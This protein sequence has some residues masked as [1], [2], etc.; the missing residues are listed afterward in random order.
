MKIILI[1]AGRIGS[2]LAFHLARAGHDVTV[3]ARGKRLDAL[4]REGA[5]VTVEG[6]RA[7]VSMLAELDPATPYDLAI[8][9][10]P[11]HQ[12][13]DLLPSLAASQ[14]KTILLMFNTFEG[15]AR[16]RSVIGAERFAFGFP[17]MT[18]ALVDRGFA[19]A[20]MASAW[21]RRCRPVRWR[22]SSGT[23]GCRVSGKQIWT[24]FFAATPRSR[25]RCS[26]R[27]C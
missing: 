2:V 11:E 27:D 22:R 16:Y 12:I 26:C 10:L 13:G 25:C 24:P 15:T 17:N 21:S 5:I 20:S 3:V 19:I 8:A 4:R 7:P 18:S 6:R 14:A 1:G 23:P 9:T